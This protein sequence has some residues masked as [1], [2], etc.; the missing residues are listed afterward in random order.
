MSRDRSFPAGAMTED[1]SM[2]M[3]TERLLLRPFRERGTPDV[4]EYPEKPKA[5]RFSRREWKQEA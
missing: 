4:P 5:N 1:E 2:A 3:E